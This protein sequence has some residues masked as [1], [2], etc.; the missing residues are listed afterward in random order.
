MAMS[1]WLRWF[2]C[3]LHRLTFDSVFVGMVNNKN[4]LSSRSRKLFTDLFRHRHF[5]FYPDSISAFP[6]VCP[7]PN[8]PGLEKSNALFFFFITCIICFL[9]GDMQAP[10]CRHNLLITLPILSD[11]KFN[12]LILCHIFTSLFIRAIFQTWK[13]LCH[14]F[15]LFLVPDICTYYHMGSP[16]RI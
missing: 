5:T 3:Y 1:R 10:G 7:C 6:W 13:S 12:A 14:G 9:A 4:E 16:H 11:W 8:C 15:T 2:T